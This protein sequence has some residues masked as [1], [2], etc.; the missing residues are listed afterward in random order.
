MTETR[1]IIRAFLASPNDLKEERKALYEVV[2]EFNETWADDF[3]YQ[4]E[5]LGWEI[6]V[7]EFGRPQHLINKDV[8]RCDIFLGMMWKRWGTPPDNQENYTSGFHE[9]FERAKKRREESGKPDICLFFKDI[10]DEYMVDKG[11]DLIKV[12]DFK[13]KIVKEKSI[14]FKEFSNISDIEKI[15]RKTISYYVS[16]IKKVEQTESPRNIE[17]Q[18]E[19]EGNVKTETTNSNISS[20]LTKEGFRFLESFM[21]KIKES[22]SLENVKDSEIARFRLLSNSISKAGNDEHYLGVHDLNLLFFDKAKYEFGEI[23]I[24]NLIKFGFRQFKNKNVMKKG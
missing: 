16:R 6:T 21:N 11:P 14:L 22:D 19:S 3:A 13:D 17:R 4:V 23:E 20:P 12:L 7:S 18:R 10:D 9:E 5:L 15:V 24:E 8:D 2:K 1:K